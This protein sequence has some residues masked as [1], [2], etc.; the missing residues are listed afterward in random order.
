MPLPARVFFYGY[1]WML[2]G[3][4]GSGILIAPW[5][6]PHVFSVNRSAMAPQSAATLLAQCRFLK[7]M[8][9]AFSLFRRVYRQ[10]IRAG[11]MARLISLAVDGVPHRAFLISA[12]PEPISGVLTGRQP[13][14]PA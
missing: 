4:G 9:F 13:L 10:R 2:P 7:S 1:T 8:E 5:E 14:R 3:A 12:G 11:G 6:L